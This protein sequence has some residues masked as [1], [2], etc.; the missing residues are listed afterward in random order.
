MNDVSVVFLVGEIFV[1]EIF[2]GYYVFDSNTKLVI[3]IHVMCMF[4]VKKKGITT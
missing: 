2:V 3:N 1:G 4:V